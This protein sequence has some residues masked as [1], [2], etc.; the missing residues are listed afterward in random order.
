MQ[1]RKLRN[2]VE[3][4][5]IGY[6]TVQPLQRFD[7][8]GMK[9][10]HEVF[11]T[12]LTTAIECGYRHIDT[13]QMY[14]NEADIGEVV[15][16]GIVP[17]SE[18]FLTT[19][20]DN[21]IGTYE[22]TLRSFDESCRKL[23]TEYLDMFLIHWP[24]PI[25]HRDRW[26][27]RNAECWRAFEKLY[28]EKR[29]R[30]IGVSNFRPRHFDALQKT[31][32]ICP[33]VD[34]IR[35]YPGDASLDN[36]TLEWCRQNG[37]LLEGYSPLGLGGVLKEPKLMALSGKYA[38]SPAQLCLKWSVQ[39]GYIPLPKSTTPERIRAN[40][41]IEDFELSAEDM[42]EMDRLP[43]VLEDDRDPDTATW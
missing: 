34:Q 21:R 2:G 35:L 8:E 27:Q 20:L 42:A 38:K 32:N 29:V 10:F 16:R 13:A 12:A 14:Y 17:R 30:A 31:A 36:P 25:H 26:Q 23:G 22:D 43:S 24:N 28:E 39:K 11:I 7:D 40:I 41:D 9:E 5:Y 18:L 37:L 19:K 33:M 3:I 1:T 15:G 6:G 4:P